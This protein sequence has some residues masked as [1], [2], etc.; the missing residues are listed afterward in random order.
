MILVGKAHQLGT[1]PLPERSM[2]GSYYG[3][4]SLTSVSGM[5]AMLCLDLEL[6]QVTRTAAA[7]N[8]D[9]DTFGHKIL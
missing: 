2:G 7:S 6:E 5:R 9:Q 8:R 1:T 4:C 3:D